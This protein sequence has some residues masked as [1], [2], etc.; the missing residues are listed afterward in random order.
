MSSPDRRLSLSGDGLVVDEQLCS[1]TAK[2]TGIRW[3]GR[4]KEAFA[5][6]TKPSLA[7]RCSKTVSMQKLM[8]ARTTIVEP[9]TVCRLRR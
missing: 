1:S 8:G 4:R 2:A 3:L 7:I 9:G 5:L 6:S